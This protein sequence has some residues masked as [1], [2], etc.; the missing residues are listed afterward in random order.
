MDPIQLEN[1][2]KIFT[3][4]FFN[5]PTFSLSQHLLKFILVFY[6]ENHAQKM[7]YVFSLLML[8]SIPLYQVPTYRPGSTLTFHDAFINS[9]LPSINIS[10]LTFL[11]ASINSS[12]SFVKSTNL[13]SIEVLTKSSHTRVSLSTSGSTY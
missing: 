13:L 8:P 7:W 10:T 11:D 9:S 2:K 5:I 12:L 6:T 3:F 4:S 1:E